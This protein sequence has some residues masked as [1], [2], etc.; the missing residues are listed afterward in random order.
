MTAHFHSGLSLTPRVVHNDLT[1]WL[2]WYG[3]RKVE[4][5]DRVKREGWRRGTATLAIPHKP[6]LQD[7]YDKNG[8]RRWV[9]EI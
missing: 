5:K 6:L 1:E 3:V 8:H 4:K 2:K 7:Y 9:E